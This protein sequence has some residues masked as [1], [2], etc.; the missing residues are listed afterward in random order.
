MKI[1]TQKRT[2]VRL[3]AAIVSVR[4]LQRRSLTHN[5]HTQ[6]GVTRSRFRV[7]NYAHGVPAIELSAPS[8]QKHFGL[9]VTYTLMYDLSNML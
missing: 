3:V 4:Q 7:V 1:R 2:E 6:M 5:V 9:S 8:S